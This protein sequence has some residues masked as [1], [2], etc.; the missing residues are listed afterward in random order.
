MSGSSR[1]TKVNKALT[2]QADT[3]TPVQSDCTFGVDREESAP[4]RLSSICFAQHLQPDSP[5][6]SPVIGE[7]VC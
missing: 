2:I 5:T 3:E 1:K 4:R 7:T 6:I